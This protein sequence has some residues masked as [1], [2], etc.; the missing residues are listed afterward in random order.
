MPLARKH[1]IDLAETSYYHCIARCV[2]R[3]YLCGNDPLT[4]RSYEH[5]KVWVIEQLR[6]LTDIFAINIC[7]YAVMSNH[8]HLVLN[9][10]SAIAEEWSPAEVVLRHRRFNKSRFFIENE[11]EI[12][13]S[14]EE[15]SSLTAEEIEKYRTKL[16]DISTFM[17]ALNEYLAR[18][19]NLEDD[20]T[21]R[22]WEGRF[23]SYALL[24]DT[25]LLTCMAYVD[26]N[27]I[28]A[29]IAGNL[30]ES[31]F[32]SIQERLREVNTTV[33]K[34]EERIVSPPI[35]GVGMNLT[36]FLDSFTKQLDA[37]VSTTIPC[38]FEEY[39]QL[40]E[41]TG[42][43]IREDKSGYIPQDVDSLFTLFS[44]E[45][46]EWLPAVTSFEKQFSWVVGAGER[47]QRIAL[48]KK[49]RWVRGIKQCVLLYSGQSSSLSATK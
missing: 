19:S 25:A 22:F 31:D 34:I 43:Q 26:L 32:T 14:E 41:W 1:Q 29:G 37:K 36:P 40:V 47:L 39:R 42:R 23:K 38:S 13:I 44:I 49:L 9:V 6:V 28:R 21:G 33:V 10:N 46:K 11:E 30:A 4:D 16:T 12:E 3:A 7:A 15:L 35:L 20:C 2:R 27:P 5:R 48:K 45:K 18:R 17:G 24:D 8:Y